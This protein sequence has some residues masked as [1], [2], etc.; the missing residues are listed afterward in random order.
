ME[1]ELKDSNS[2]DVI[3]FSHYTRVVIDSWLKIALF[4]FMVSM[5]SVLLV[6]QMTPKYTATATLLIEAQEKKAISID[7]VVGFDSSQKEYYQTQYEIIQSDPIAQRVIDKLNLSDNPRFNVSLED[8][9]ISLSQFVKQL[10]IISSLLKYDEFG[11]A[12]KKQYD[13][14]DD[15]ISQDILHDFKKSLSINPVRNTQLVKISFTAEEPE[16]AAQIANEIGLAYIEKN[17]EGRL[18][19]TKYASNWINARAA[20]LQGQLVQSEKAL[21]DYL[22]QEKLIDDS[23]IDALA[24][25][26]L[27]N[28]TQSLSDV[29]DRRIEVESAY[30]ALSTSNAKDVALIS[31]IPSISSHPQVVA[32][33]AAE[34]QA[35]NEVNEL[36]KRYGEKHDKMIA[37]QAR[38]DA[39]KERATTTTSQL[40]SGFRKELQALR[41]QESL[42]EAT[43]NQRRGEFQALSIKKNKYESLKRDVATNRD[44]LNVFLTRQKETSATKD[45]NSTIASVVAEARTP[46]YPSGT[47]KSLI[48]MATFALSF[49]FAIVL[50]IIIDAMRNTIT[51]NADF[52]DRFG[53]IPLGSVPRVKTA[54]FEKK[55][56]DNSVFFDEHENAFIEAI[57]SIRTSLMLNNPNHRRFSITSS[58]ASEG[59][60]TVA[61]NIAMALSNMESTILIDGDLRKSAV[62][63]RFGLKKYQQGLNNHLML[64]TDLADCLYKDE[65]SGLTIL[66]A[67]MLTTDT[68]ELLN[69]DKFAEL[70]NTLETQF[71]Y[72]IIDTPPTLPVSDSLIIGQLTQ[73]MLLVVK[74]NETKQDSVKKAFAKLR[75]HDI[76]IEGVVV[77]QISRKLA[78]VEYGYGDYGKYDNSNEKG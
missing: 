10:P 66:P 55:A 72:I 38:L 16:L 3:D 28:L 2:E 7:E 43:I 26:E 44:L 9:G 65:Q 68:Q 57:R 35:Q 23:G 32:I 71:K 78:S 17:L 18:A 56:L 73:K 45:F 74:A 62:A 21:S 40:I 49:G 63:E 36:R 51:S 39:V 67:G 42:I 64:G 15:K 31:S 12:P 60:T 13:Q 54:R 34:L 27:A 19:V 37:A 30:S 75:K 1:D 20:E 52:E 53:L 48:V 69:S 70:L 59:K 41:K 77:N 50:V 11:P 29:R 47:S 4:C 5:L 61:I 33:R 6:L 14:L 24:S 22:V 58:L 76:K 46:H 8:D 25:R